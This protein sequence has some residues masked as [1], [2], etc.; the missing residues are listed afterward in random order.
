MQK[1]FFSFVHERIRIRNMTEIHR[2]K[3]WRKLKGLMVVFLII[4]SFAGL[5]FGQSVKENKKDNTPFPAYGKGKINVR[6][7][8]DYFCSPCRASE[9]K[10]EPA[11]EK[12]VKK[13]V[14]TVTFIDT[15]IHPVSPLYA[16]HFLY[17]LKA[18][19]TFA[20]ALSARRALFEAAEKRIIDK[21]KLE[22]HLKQKKIAFTVFDTT[23]AFIMLNT[24]INND[25]IRSTPS[26][27]IETQG[28]T[29]TFIGS[30]SILDALNALK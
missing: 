27:V 11:I 23:P 2:I 3:K 25:K 26:C 12:L 6:I 8:T 10:I 18:K 21:N 19:N 4:I 20:H 28:K 5:S 13:D 22:A 30:E 24:L 7:Y 16:K 29:K 17:A 9:P 15:P 14:I 1:A